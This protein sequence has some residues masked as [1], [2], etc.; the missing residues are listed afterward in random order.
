MD[1][2]DNVGL[3]YSAL[4]KQGF[5]DIG[6]ENIFRSKMANENN[7]KILYEALN[8]KG[9]NDIGDYDTFNSKLNTNSPSILHQEQSQP[10]P[11]SPYVEGKG[12]DTM[13]FGVPYADYQQMTPEEQSKQYSAAIEKRKNDEKDFFSNYISG[14]LGEIDSELSNKREP[15]PMPA[16]SAFI[17]SSAV[18]AAQR[19]GNDD[20]K[21]TQDRYT[22]LHAAKNLLDD[23]N[24]LVEEVKKGDTG[25]FS[26]LGRGFKDK[27]MDTDN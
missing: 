24:K 14:Q 21:E 12:E 8:K 2:K 3:L 11:K 20:T 17:P 4:K 27:F 10:R 22:S 19:F 7:R 25:F 1:T 13:I 6:D 5:N 15:L 23:A 16:G 26:S 9:F 18:G